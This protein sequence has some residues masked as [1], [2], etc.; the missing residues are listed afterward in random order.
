M[1]SGMDEKQGNS[2]LFCLEWKEERFVYGFL[3]H[4]LSVLKARFL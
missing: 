3:N 4:L 1:A 2:G